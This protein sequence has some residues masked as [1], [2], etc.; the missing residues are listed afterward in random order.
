MLPFFDHI[1]SPECLVL[2]FITSNFMVVAHT[3]PLNSPDYYRIL[4]IGSGSARGSLCIVARESS[5]K[6]TETRTP[7]IEFLSYG[8]HF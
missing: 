3:I 8:R 1:L 4:A 5:T 7:A 6:Q 2:F